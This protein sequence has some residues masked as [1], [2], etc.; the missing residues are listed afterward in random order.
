[1]TTSQ[2]TAKS[3]TVTECTIGSFKF[4]FNHFKTFLKLATL[5]AVISTLVATI[6]IGDTTY[7]DLNGFGTVEMKYW[8]AQL[9]DFILLIMFSA[10]YLTHYLNPDK[11][12]PMTSVLVWN[13]TKTEYLINFLKIAIL[14]SFIAI[15]IFTPIGIIMAKSQSLFVISI[16]AIVAIGATIWIQTYKTIYAF[17]LPAAIVG[18]PLSFKQTINLS[19]NFKARIAVN[20]TIL[21]IISLSFL[22]LAFTI[23]DNLISTD[24]IPRQ[25]IDLITN[26]FEY[27]SLAINLAFIGHIYN[28][29]MK[30]K[31]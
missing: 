27:L 17:I 3:L 11:E 15:V 8:I 22:V 29:L 9:V 1:M 16:L 31:Y 24:I 7:D 2:S 10:T 28:F 26:C 23:A 20:A 12:I 14:F 5:P 6:L 4:V 25:A 18:N 30:T 13:K 21:A 19:N